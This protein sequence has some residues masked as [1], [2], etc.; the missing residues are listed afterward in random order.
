MCIKFGGGQ[1]QVAPP[2]PPLAPPPPPPEKP[3]A[4]LPEPEAVDAE[5]NP[6]VRRTKSQKDKNPYAQGTGSLRIKLDPSVNT[7]AAPGPS[8]GLNQ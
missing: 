8:G 6:Q 2:P 7:G 1:K 4:P 3:T 5:V